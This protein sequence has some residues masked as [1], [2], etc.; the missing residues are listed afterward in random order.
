MIGETYNL[1]LAKYTKCPADLNVGKAQRLANETLAERQFNRLTTL[2][3][4]PQASSDVKF[5]EKMRDA[6]PGISEA[7]VCDVVVRA[8]PI[9]SDLELFS[10]RHPVP[11]LHIGERPPDSGFG[12]VIFGFELSPGSFGELG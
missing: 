8:P 10:Y 12:H 11:L 7:D 4:K 6:L 2:S 1:L 5:K 9:R 3:W